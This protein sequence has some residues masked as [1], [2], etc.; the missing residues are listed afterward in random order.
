MDTD[1]VNKKSN[2]TTFTH[3]K[4][5]STFLFFSFNN[6]MIVKLECVV[7]DKK[8]VRYKNAPLLYPPTYS[9]E[10]EKH[11]LFDSCYT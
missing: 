6:E 1:W 3:F 10:E 2:V 5:S 8:H 7:N 9:F 4:S 11:T